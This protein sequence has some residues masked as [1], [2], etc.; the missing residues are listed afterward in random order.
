MGG[1][2]EKEDRM[3]SFEIHLN[4]FDIY[5][6]SLWIVSNSHSCS[7]IVSHPVRWVESTL[8]LPWFGAYSCDLSFPEN[9]RGHDT[10]VHVLA[11]FRLAPYVSF[12][13]REKH[14]LSSSG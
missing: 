10:E 14:A 1:E 7:V 11:G 8:P 5:K 4:I 3:L 9:E 13:P 2:A 6:N 12:L